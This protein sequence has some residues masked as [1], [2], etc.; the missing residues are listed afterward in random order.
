MAKRLT[1]ELLSRISKEDLLS[2]YVKDNHTVDETLAYFDI[3]NKDYFFK[4]LKIYEIK[5]PRSLTQ[6][7]IEKTF[8]D[9]YGCTTPLNSE[10][11]KNK[12]RQTKLERYGSETYNN[13]DKSK[14][15][16]IEKY[17]VDNPFKDTERIK[18][19]YID[20]FGTDHPMKSEVIRAKYRNTMMENYGVEYPVQDEQIGAVIHSKGSET[21]MKRYGCTNVMSNP[22]IRQK[23]ID[24]HKERYGVDYPCQLQQCSLK[25]NDSKPNKAID[26]LLTEMD[27]EHTREF[28]LHHYRYD[29]KVGNTLIEVDPSATHNVTWAPLGEPITPNYHKVKSDTAKSNGY[30]CIHIFDWE[31]PV[32]VLSLLIPRQRI[33]ARKCEVRKI[34]QTTANKFLNEHHIQ[35]GARL[36]TYCLGLYYEDALVSVMTFGNPRYNKKYEWELIRYCS[37]YDV[38]GGANKLWAHFIA[39]VN[40]QSVISYCDF[41][42]FNGDT[43]L[44]LGM[45]YKSISIGKHWY[46]LNT[47][48]HITDNFLRQRGFD[49]IFH[50]NYGKGTSNEELMLESGYVE[51]YDCGQITFEYISEV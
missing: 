8:E 31:D 22:S 45:K 1:N 32:K 46:N 29:F 3:P 40:P 9:K 42:K 47:G 25:G 35:G 17:G 37:T 2:Y 48:D 41:S 20:K 21:N 43:Y 34:D 36:Q 4:L 14:Q 16:C 18:Q 10:D 13:R 38:I 39:D 12:S 27:I 23:W 50:T 26:A 44:K 19:S 6:K 30:R 49:Q 15:T 7:H 28:P 51:V 24:A 5:K 33:Y 11:G